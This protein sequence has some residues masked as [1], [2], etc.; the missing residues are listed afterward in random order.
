M[1]TLF[2]AIIASFL[3]STTSV[4]GAAAIFSG[5]D[6]KI[7]K[8][9]LD[10][11]GTAKV[12]SGALN[13]SATPVSAPRGSIYLRT[14]NGTV[15]VKGDAGSSTNWTLMAAGGAGT[16]DVV[17]PATATDNAVVRYDGTTGE[18]I[19]DSGVT[20]SDTNILTAAGVLVS[21][22]TASRACVTDGSKNLASSATTATE[23]GYV[24]GV[25]SALQTQLDAKQASLTT[26]LLTA[27]TPV[28]VSGAR[29]VIGGAAAITIDNAAAD[30]S[31]KG[32]ASFAAADFNA[33]SGN[34]TIDYPNGLAATDA[35]QGFMSAANHT[36][37][38]A[39]TTF[40]TAAT[41]AA[42]V[43]TGVKRGTSNEAYV[44]AFPVGG[45]GVWWKDDFMSTVVASEF[46][47]AAASSGGTN[48]KR[49]DSENNHPG[50]IKISTASG[51]TDRYH[52]VGDQAAVLLG[53]G[54]WA[55]E[56]LIYIDTLSDGVDTYAIRAGFSDG[57]ATDGTDGCFFKYL[58]T[59][60]VNWLAGCVS[61]ATVAL[62]TTSTAVAEDTWLTLRMEVNAAGTSVVFKVNGT[63]ISTE[64][65]NIPTGAGRQTGPVIGILKS[66]GTSAR[67]FYLD[68][69]FMQFIPTADRG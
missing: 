35:L 52:L 31:T 19:Q 64:T 21:G 55:M 51:T 26:G 38:T 33:S 49:T 28:N 62:E 39:N 45:Q 29:T 32:A 67:F 44:N 63:T 66:A 47:W 65:D 50:Q 12:M 10:L 46:A 22:L 24:N 5:S 54:A 9:N 6:V 58:S 60:S 1:K 59:T 17:G 42:T 23:L 56:W 3:F 18:S 57:T 25:T 20:I 4:Y 13:P 41:S 61:N 53:G 2:K 15:Y 14:D 43:S 36:S 30:G 48:A 27:T 16:G 69:F 34:I 68:R 37:F 11:N 7:L 8:A 40:V